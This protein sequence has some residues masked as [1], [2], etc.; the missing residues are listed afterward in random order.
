MPQDQAT[1][2]STGVAA[3]SRLGKRGLAIGGFMAVGKSTVGELVAGRLGLPFV[4]LDA[5][6]VQQEG[7]SIPQLFAT[8]GEPGFRRAERRALEATLAGGPSVLALGGGTLHADTGDTPGN[9]ALVRNDRPV[10]VLD[11]AWD[12]LEARLRGD[13]SRPLAASAATL[14][15]Q[16]RP[17]YLSAGT[18]VDVTD[19]SPQAAADRVVEL[20]T[21]D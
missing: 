7:S 12:R 17:G 4:D 3:A 2:A 1:P 5:V 8:R 11:C 19:L 16:R 18:V 6:I 9:L 10:V 20:L 21:C 14:W 15:T 13:G